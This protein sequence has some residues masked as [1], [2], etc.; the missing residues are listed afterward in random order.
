MPVATDAIATPA[1][2]RVLFDD[3][4]MQSTPGEMGRSGQSANP[5][6]NDDDLFGCHDFPIR[7]GCAANLCGTV[8]KTGEVNKAVNADQAIHKPACKLFRSGYSARRQ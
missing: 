6:P 1:G 4:D 3:R 7:T 8:F 2:M 5:R